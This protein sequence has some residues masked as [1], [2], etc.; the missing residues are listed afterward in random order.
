[1]LRQSEPNARAKPDADCNRDG[2][3][4]SHSNG[5]SDRDS[6]SD[7]DRNSHSNADSDGSAESDTDANGSAKPHPNSYAGA[8]FLAVDQSFVCDRRAQ[9]RHRHL[10][11][12]NHADRRFRI[13]ADDVCERSSFWSNRDVLAEPRGGFVDDSYCHSRARRGEGNVSVYRHGN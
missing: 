10:H 7:R 6:N 1:M 12:Y 9:R 8:E 2:Y 3:C 5:N 4:R 11:R 13:G